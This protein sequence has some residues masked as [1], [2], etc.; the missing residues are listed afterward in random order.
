MEHLIFVMRLQ[1]I[2][3]LDL[4]S[5]ILRE[6]NSYFWKQNR[7]TTYSNWPFNDSDKCN[8]DS[9]AAAGFYVVGDNTE[10]DLVQ[11]FIC[12]KQLDGWEPNDDPWYVEQQYDLCIYLLLFLS[13]KAL[14]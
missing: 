1:E 2:R 12:G 5:L 9:M 3:L 4:P 13:I 14:K 11:C 10:P 6:A 8:A 7:R